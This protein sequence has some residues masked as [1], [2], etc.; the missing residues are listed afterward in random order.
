MHAA[1][2]PALVPSQLPPEADD[3]VVRFVHQLQMEVVAPLFS[4]PSEEAFLEILPDL[5]ARGAILRFRW[6]NS[7]MELPAERQTAII[8]LWLQPPP[9]SMRIDMQRRAARLLGEERSFQ[10]ERALALTLSDNVEFSTRLHAKV[11]SEPVTDRS[12]VHIA[13]LAEV[14]AVHDILSLGWMMVLFGDVPSPKPELARVAASQ[15]FAATSERLEAM[16]MALLDMPSHQVTTQSRWVVPDGW[17]EAHPLLKQP[18]LILQGLAF[19]DP[20]IIA[21]AVTVTQDP[22]D[23]TLAWLQIHLTVAGENPDVVRLRLEDRAL[24]AGVL[25]T[26]SDDHAMIALLTEAA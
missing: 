16:R 4:A 25:G 14:G 3:G 1:R 9:Q 6:I 20:A 12:L 24:R 8:N 18:T 21:I 15:L 26:M 2:I 22:E 7:V 5:L 11:S 13:R 19:D 17:L 23:A 10:L